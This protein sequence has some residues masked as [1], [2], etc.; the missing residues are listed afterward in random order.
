MTPKSNK[1][2]KLQFCIWEITDINAVKAEGKNPFSI[3]NVGS[4]TC[5]LVILETELVRK[6][7]TG[8]SFIPNIYNA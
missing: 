6:K 1:N 2:P 3:G 4:G 7:G 5:H 8:S